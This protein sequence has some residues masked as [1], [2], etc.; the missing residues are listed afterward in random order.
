MMLVNMMLMI[1]MNIMPMKIDDHDVDP[2]ESDS[3]DEYNDHVYV[4][5]SHYNH[6]CMCKRENFK[7]NSRWL[8]SVGMKLMMVIWNDYDDH[9]K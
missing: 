7:Q 8:R 2:D 5:N 1:L 6:G 9:K 4:I 3:H